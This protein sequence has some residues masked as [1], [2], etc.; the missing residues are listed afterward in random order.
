MAAEGGAAAA[1]TLDPAMLQMAV[2][3]PLARMAMFPGSPFTAESVAGLVV[4]ANK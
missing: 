2:S 3:I 4:A 1:L